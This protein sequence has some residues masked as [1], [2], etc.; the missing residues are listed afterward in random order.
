MSTGWINAL[1]VSA[2]TTRTSESQ[3]PRPRPI[4]R[5]AESPNDWMLRNGAAAQQ[6]GGA[7]IHE[8]ASDKPFAKLGPGDASRG[9]SSA[10]ARRSADRAMIAWNEMNHGTE[11]GRTLSLPGSTPGMYRN[12]ASENTPAHVWPM[13]QVQAAALGVAALT[14][15]AGAVRLLDPIMD[16]HIHGGAYQPDIDHGGDHN[17]YTDDNMAIGLNYIQAYRQSGD[18]AYV[19]KAE[20]ILPFLEGMV[21]EQTGGLNWREGSTAYV[22]DSLA[23]AQK[24]ALLLAQD[25][26]D[27]GIR[28]RAVA[29]AHKLDAFTEANLRAHDGDKAG[30]LLDNVQSNNETAQWK[31]LIFSYNEGWSIG[32]DIEW[33]RTT[34]DLAYLDRARTT[35]D[36]TLRYYDAQAGGD[37][38]WKQPP[39]FN[40]N[41]F[42]NLLAL[43]AID[44]PAD[45]SRPYEQR[46]EQYLDRAWN[47]A[48]DPESGW[49][50]QGGIGSFTG[51][52]SSG[53]VDTLDQAGMVQM[54]A[55]L[56]MKPAD[57]ATTV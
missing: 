19:G 24:F 6:L 57:R 45:G 3:D 52:D 5:T 1:P 29:F 9:A 14:G 44:P 17:R 18:R 51:G 28:D 10:V 4:A 38:L 11:D 15:S 30:L 37:G 33:Y 27:P 13:S 41:F 39:S 53:H 46:L 12:Q 26:T 23:G 35:A 25:T 55:L 31:D 49:F 34:G 50:H 2:T 43:E 56:A 40:A 20:A 54:Y 48:R 8:A 32:A 22:A 16:R 42:E 36:A 47:E 7:G 21:N